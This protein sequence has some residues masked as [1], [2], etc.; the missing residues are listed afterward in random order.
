MGIMLLIGCQDDCTQDAYCQLVSS[1][2]YGKTISVKGDD[3]IKVCHNGTTLE[4]NPNALQGHLNHGD[5]E[6]ACQVLSSNDLEFKDG[7]VVEIPCGYSL[8]FIHVTDN[9][10]Q[11]LYSSLEN[12]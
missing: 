4:V 10:A 2:N 8:P 9:G 3:K 7:E 1:Q 5:T 6:G 12:R 11:W